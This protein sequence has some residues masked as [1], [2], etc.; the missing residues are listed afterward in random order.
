[1]AFEVQIPRLGWSMEEGV[2]VEWLKQDGDAVAPGD[3]LY[4]LEGEKAIQEIEAIDEGILR[5]RPDGP[6]EGDVVAVGTVIAWLCEADEPLPWEQPGADTVT[7]KDSTAPATAP[8]ASTS[9]PSSVATHDSKNRP[10]ASPRARRV[11]A[12]LG[13]DWTTLS[14]SGR[15]GRIRESDVRAACASGTAATVKIAD[16]S[17]PSGVST[18]RQAIAGRVLAASQS[19]APVTLTTAVD[20]TQL[21]SLRRQFQATGG[22]GPCPGYNDILVKLTAVVLRDH[23][24]L[25]SSWADN[26]IV[27]NEQID[28][29]LAVETEVGL[30]APVIRDPGSLPLRELSVQIAELVEQ[31]RQRKL[32]ADEMSGG[33]FTITNLGSYG[34]DVF[35]PVLNLPQSAILGVGRIRNVPA[36][37]GEEILPRDE[38]TLSL[39]FDHR[40]LDGAPA[41][42]FLS[43]LGQAIENP[44]AMLVV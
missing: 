44:G 15:T 3:T 30:L 27:V 19:T 11:A 28:I 36:V 40:V 32:S 29:A 8:L 37:I 4:N 9:T 14:G 5:V 35:T 38:I 18:T 22:D 33:A 42:E 1:M 26:G 31:A 20:A 10:A 34:I 7:G 25:R 12:E 16:L 21:V 17:S 43:Q 6:N 23:P 41:A 39:T 13:V 2:F 24:S